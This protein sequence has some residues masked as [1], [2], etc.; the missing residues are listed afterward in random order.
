[1]TRSI[2][3]S[4][5]AWLLCLCVSPWDFCLGGASRPALS[6][7]VSILF[8]ETSPVSAVSWSSSHSLFLTSTPPPP[9]VSSALFPPAP[10]SPPR[11]PEPQPCRLHGSHLGEGRGFRSSRDHAGPSGP[12]DLGQALVFVVGPSSFMRPSDPVCCP[13]QKAEAWGRR[14]GTLPRLPSRGWDVWKSPGFLGQELEEGLVAPTCHR[15][16]SSGDLQVR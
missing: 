9:C 7:P 14:C 15:S 13:G 2:P 8:T 12:S 11:R 5:G 6:A 1:M 4:G 10:S 16:V 3:L